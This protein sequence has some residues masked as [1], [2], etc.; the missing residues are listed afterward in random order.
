MLRWQDTVSRCCWSAREA[1][2][3][4]KWKRFDRPASSATKVRPRRWTRLQLWILKPWNAHSAELGSEWEGARD[5]RLGHGPRVNQRPGSRQV[6]WVWSPACLQRREQPELVF[7]ISRITVQ[8]FAHFRK[9]IS[10]THYLL[11]SCHINSF[12]CYIYH[13]MKIKFWCYLHLEIT[14][15]TLSYC[16]CGPFF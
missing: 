13:L 15:I 16:R 11:N 3:H 2:V 4:L 7:S 8:S 9:Q 14:Y 6:R 10:L 1:G 5:R 12:L